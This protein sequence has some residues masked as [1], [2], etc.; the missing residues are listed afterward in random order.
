VAD[1]RQQSANKLGFDDGKDLGLVSLDQCVERV[2]G[3]LERGKSEP[4]AFSEN[5]EVAQEVVLEAS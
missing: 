4:D 5:N 3:G 1:R 2:A